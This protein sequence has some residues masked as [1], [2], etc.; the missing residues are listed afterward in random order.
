MEHRS[1]GV[2]L[3]AWY[4]P[5]RALRD[6]CQRI[7][8]VQIAKLDFWFFDFS[9]RRNAFGGKAIP[10]NEW[11][12]DSP[13]D[14]A[15][16]AF[17]WLVGTP[18][19]RE[20][21]DAFAHTWDTPGRGIAAALGIPV[22]WA[23]ETCAICRD[24]DADAPPTLHRAILGCFKWRFESGWTEAYDMSVETSGS[25]YVAVYGNPRPSDG[26]RPVLGQTW[27][28][29]DPTIPVNWVALGG[30]IPGPTPIAEQKLIDDGAMR[31]DFF[32]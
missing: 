4:S 11:F 13:F 17:P 8:F 23:F 32:K 9:A 3:D 26:T 19:S 31:G 21:G 16:P 1:L 29:A 10:D 28:S 20:R 27:V 18:W 2:K 30:E 25:R 5:T 15:N 7:E 14:P 22:S 6:C 24:T 12:V